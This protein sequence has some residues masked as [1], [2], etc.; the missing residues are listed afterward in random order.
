MLAN[1]R[2]RVA[3]IIGREKRPPKP[4]EGGSAKKLF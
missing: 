2:P 3:E 1:L 4:A